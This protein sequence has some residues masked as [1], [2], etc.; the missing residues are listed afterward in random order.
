MS[1]LTDAI[2]L[3][4]FVGE[5]DLYQGKPL[6]SAIIS[7]AIENHVA[8]AT[9]LY[10]RDGFGISRALRTDFYSIDGGP[11]LP[12][13]IEMIDSETKINN[14]LPVLNEM[15]GSGL[16]TLEKVRARQYH[17]RGTENRFGNAL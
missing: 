12:M 11:Q 9:V 8:G 5:N 2:L 15:I 14:F 4:V 1:D 16:V 13:V 10:G 6:I 7:K 17:R 3:R